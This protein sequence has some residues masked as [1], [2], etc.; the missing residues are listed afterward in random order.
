MA[1]SATGIDFRRDLLGHLTRGMHQYGDVVAYH[2]GPKH[3]PVRTRIVVVHHPDQVQQVL[4]QTERTFTKDSIAFRNLAEMLGR[5][6]LTTDGDEWKRQRRLV[7]PLFTPRRVAG[8]A[9]L[10]SQE[11]A[12]RGR[13]V[14]GRRQRPSTSTC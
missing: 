14:P 5:G 1:R 7:Q 2:L 8:Y 9:D 6:L 12:A 4:S 3:T 10:M 11:A 13:L